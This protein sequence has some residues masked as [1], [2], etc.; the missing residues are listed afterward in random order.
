MPL[1]REKSNSENFSFA[2]WTNVKQKNRQ[3][4]KPKKKHRMTSPEIQSQ[5]MNE[6]VRTTA[7]DQRIIFSIGYLKGKRSKIG[8]KT[9]KPNKLN[10]K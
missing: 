10:E 1:V 5:E 9:K 2:V 6:K 7:S 3:T 4:I 8:G